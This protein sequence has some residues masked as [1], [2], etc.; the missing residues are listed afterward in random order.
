M[1]KKSLHIDI[2]NIETQIALTAIAEGLPCFIWEEDGKIIIEC[3]EEDSWLI[4]CI[5]KSH[6]C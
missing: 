2:E 5:M 1:V 6:I 4:D 3:R